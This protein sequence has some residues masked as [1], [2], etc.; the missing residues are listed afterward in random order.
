MDND[1]S[2]RGTTR[3]HTFFCTNK[4]RHTESQ[5]IVDIHKKTIKA[6]GKTVVGWLITT[7]EQVIE[8]IIPAKNSIIATDSLPDKDPE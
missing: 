7:E 2:E 3:R 6:F 1:S 4:D 8:T 5:N